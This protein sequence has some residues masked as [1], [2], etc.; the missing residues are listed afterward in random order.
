MTKSALIGTAAAVFMT[1]LTPTTLVAQDSYHLRFADIGPPR[2]TR[3]EVMMWWADE[4][5]SRSDGRVEIEFFWG[6]AL[7]NPASMVDSVGSGL[8]DMGYV[9]GEYTTLLSRMAFASIPYVENDPWVAMR[10]TFDTV[11]EN[12]D[13]QDQ[14][15]ETGVQFL[16]TFGPGPTQILSREPITTVEEFAGKKFQGAG[17]WQDWGKAM[18]AVPVTLPYHEGYPALERGTTDALQGWITVTR[19]YKLYEVSPHITL[20]NSGMTTSTGVVINQELFDSMPADLKA[21][22]Q[23]TSV[24]LMDRYA[25]AL[26]AETDTIM[27]ALTQGVDGYKVTFHELPEDELARWKERAAFLVPAYVEAANESGLDGQAIWDAYSANLEKYR[28]IVA[29]EG[30]PWTE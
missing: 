3:A 4:I 21:I 16:N 15:A 9:V 18:G 13:V 17:A 12:E 10:A 20:A 8:A 5:K 7:A 6:G 26:T 28:Q 11:S 24:E 23:D 27:E 25:Q 22:L 30:H 2:G 19:A 1:A 29:T 14:L